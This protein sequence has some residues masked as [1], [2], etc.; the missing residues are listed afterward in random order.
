[1]VGAEGAAVK[2]KTA[3]VIPVALGWVEEAA[4]PCLAAVE[5]AHELTVIDGRE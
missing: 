1:M 4:H 2:A 5:E 3:P